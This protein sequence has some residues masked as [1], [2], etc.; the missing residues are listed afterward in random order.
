MPH[1]SPT[2]VVFCFCFRR[3]P[4][5][6]ALAGLAFQRGAVRLT[7]HPWV[8]SSALERVR[9]RGRFEGQRDASLAQRGI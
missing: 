5:R 6:A 4:L 8:G 2:L 9:V 7:G 3:A 1:A